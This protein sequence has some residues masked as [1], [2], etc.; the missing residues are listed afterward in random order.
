MP[1]LFNPHELI[2][3]KKESRSCF[4]FSLI[5]ILATSEITLGIL[6]PPTGLGLQD[7]SEGHTT[8]SPF[9][10]PTS[11]SCPHSVCFAVVFACSHFLRFLKGAS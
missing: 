8:R 5:L 6:T 9:W 4:S 2:M 10:L 1:M 11:L 7:V 3:P